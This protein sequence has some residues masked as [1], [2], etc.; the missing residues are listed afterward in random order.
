MVDY[1]V[2]FFFVIH[3]V[4]FGRGAKKRKMQ[5]NLAHPYV[6]TTKRNY[7]AVHITQLEIEVHGDF[8]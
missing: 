2:H 8:K 3:V 4:P 7:L 5:T 1:S 6:K